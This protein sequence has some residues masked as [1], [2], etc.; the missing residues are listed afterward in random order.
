MTGSGKATGQTL[1]ACIRINDGQLDLTGTLTGTKTGWHEQIVL[2]LEDSA[3]DDEGSY[4][5]PVCIAA[6]CTFSTT[7]VPA[8]GEW[9]V[10]PQ[11]IKSG[12]IQSSGNEP[13]YVSF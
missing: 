5:S 4:T 2:V 7:L 12:K 11:W 8:S 10:L 1:Q 9:T 6:D 3:Q 13:A